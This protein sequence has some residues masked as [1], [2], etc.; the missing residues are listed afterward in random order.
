MKIILAST[1]PRRVQLLAAAKIKA[2][3]VAPLCDESIFKDESPRR[4]VRRLSLTKAHSVALRLRP[5]TRLGVLVI[6]ADTVVVEPAGRRILN[7]PRS[8]TEAKRMLGLIAGRTHQVLTGFT[9]LELKGRSRRVLT[10]VVSSQVTMRQLSRQQIAAYV[11]TG[12]PMDK[13]GAYA[14]QGLGMNFITSIR[15]SYTNVVGLPM[16]ELL[17]ALES[18]FGVVTLA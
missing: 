8:A 15:G 16:A 3:A 5:S 1:S 10:R 9:I 4:L 6:A 11:R 2:K 7:K 17:E 12:E 13:A 14:A 18:K